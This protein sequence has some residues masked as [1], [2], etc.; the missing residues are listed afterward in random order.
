MPSKDAPAENGITAKQD[1]QKDDRGLKFGTDVVYDDAYGGGGESEYVTSLPTL[2]E[3]KKIY[4]EGVRAKEEMEE[5]DEG[6]VSNHPSTLAASK[7]GK[8]SETRGF[9]DRNLMTFHF[10]CI[11]ITCYLFF[12]YRLKTMGMMK[13]P[14]PTLPEG[15]AW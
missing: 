3:E 4:G 14:L 8:V 15:R 13:T 7:R 5:L 10:I 11:L 12:V 1:D 6:R 2:D 9:H